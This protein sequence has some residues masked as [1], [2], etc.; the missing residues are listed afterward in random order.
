MHQPL[1]WRRPLPTLIGSKT[2]K[3]A[4]KRIREQMLF[5]KLFS[6]RS[7]DTTSSSSIKGQIILKVKEARGLTTLN[8]NFNFLSLPWPEKTSKSLRSSRWAQLTSKVD[9]KKAESTDSPESFKFSS[10]QY[11]ILRIWNLHSRQWTIK[12]V[13]KRLISFIKPFT[14]FRTIIYT[15][16][17]EILPPFDTFLISL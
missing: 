12:T 10:V 5:S 15:S 6:V 17:L 14:C 9:R 7:G 1:N 8:S 13:V 3:F 2:L 4:W 11:S 16:F